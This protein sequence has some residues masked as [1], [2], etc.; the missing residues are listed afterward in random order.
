M[1]YLRR[2]NSGL[3]ALSFICAQVS[4]AGELANNE[5]NEVWGSDDNIASIEAYGATDSTAIIVQKSGGGL[6]GN[7]SKIKISGH[8]N[9][10][11]SH[12]EGYYNRSYIE[13]D[14]NEN[15]A[16]IYQNGIGNDGSIEQYGNGNTAI[17]SQ[18]GIGHSDSITQHGDD[19]LAVVV[20]KPY[21]LFSGFDI[22]Q[23]GHE[24]IMILNG[25]S[26]N[27]SVY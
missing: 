22:N 19:N 20:N 1:K 8:D 7:Q 2:I 25:M 13:Q 10:A 4:T 15:Y 6:G 23:S 12:Q 17:L 11:Y 14:G 26:R 9:F 21:V 27:I 16:A 3:F 24:S 5:L 18:S